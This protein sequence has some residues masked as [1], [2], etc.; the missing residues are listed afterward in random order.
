MD[1]INIIL[2]ITTKSFTKKMN[3]LSINR[4]SGD[5][6]L[7]RVC[8]LKSNRLFVPLVAI[9]FDFINVNVNTNGVL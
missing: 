4:V 7:G 9:L 5:F 6:S 1:I 3:R 2:I 8:R